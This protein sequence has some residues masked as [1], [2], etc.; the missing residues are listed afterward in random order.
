MFHTTETLCFCVICCVCIMCCGYCSVLS[1][2]SFWINIIIIG[3]GGRVD[4][5]CFWIASF[6][7]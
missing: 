6:E 7:C 3:G 5:I 4:P 2:V 1:L